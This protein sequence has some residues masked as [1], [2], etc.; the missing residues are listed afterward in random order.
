[1]PY[2]ELNVLNNTATDVAVGIDLGTTNSLVAIWR[3]GRP[4]VL[5]PEGRSGLVPSVVYVPSEGTPVVGREARDQAV[6]D[7]RHTVFSIKR[8]MGRGLADVRSEL[9]ARP[10]SATQT[11]R[12]LVQLELRG[13]KYT[14]QEL[15][16]LILMKV[17]DV[18][19]AALGGQPVTRAVIT[20]PAYF[21]DAQRQATRDAAHL[22]GLEVLRIVNEPTAAS[23]AYGLDQ[24]D[25]GNVAVFDL[26]GGTFDVSI[27]AIEDGVFRVLST[28]G[29]THLGGDDFD[30]RLAELA[31]SE[32]GPVAGARVLEDP[33][34]QQAVRLAAERCKIE[35]TA[36]PEADLHL[37][38]PELRLNWRRRVTREEFEGR[39][40]DLLQRAMD[41][42]RRALSD[43]HLKA[44]QVDEVVLVGGSTRVPIVR[45]RV[46]AFFGRK[47]HTE[48]DP[49]QVVALGAAVQAHILTGGKRDMLLMDV[50]P[51]SLGI[52][53]MGGAVDKVIQRNTTIPCAATVGYTTYADNQTGLDFHIVQGERELAKDCRSLGRFQLKGVPPMPAGLARI[54]VRFHIDADG[55]LRVSAKEESTGKSA[56]IDV[57]PMHGLTD[58]EVE[59]M[60]KAGFAHARDDFQARRAADLKIEIGTMLHAT[61]KHLHAAHG[62]LDKETYRDLEDA[63]SRAREA[64][65]QDDGT[66]LQKARDELERATLPLAALLMNNVAQKALMGR[67]L[68]DV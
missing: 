11:E 52:E 16:A 63:I 39:V 21:D 35:L 27:L 22:A 44:A 66:A 55:V 68:G 32:I 34:F 54:A 38:V 9:A 8:F 4:V 48:L 1:M 28:N 29:D 7:P 30:E 50:T 43:A 26:G 41:C 24:R 45:A 15:S 56:Q 46:E 2:I 18:A 31:R 57:Q 64:A 51:L 33:G 60:L 10:Y 40:A 61:E 6:V 3:D 20:V 47:P 59:G 58:L 65:R 23:L 19:C 53:T 5:A 62:G 25:K 12:G 17:R 42:C 13:R 36:Q 37:V 49:D 67:K 14:P